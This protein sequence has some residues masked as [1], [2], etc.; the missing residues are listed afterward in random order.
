MSPAF[1]GGGEVFLYRL[2]E[3]MGEDAFRDAIK[4]YYMDYSMRIATT[5]DFIQVITKYA[6]DNQEV[7]LLLQKYLRN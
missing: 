7:E 6:P 2:K 3:A 4:K 5:E 1:I